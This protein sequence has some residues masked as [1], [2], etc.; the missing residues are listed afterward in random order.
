MRQLEQPTCQFWLT[1]LSPEIAASSQVAISLPLANCTI[2]RLAPC[3]SHEAQYPHCFPAPTA[4]K[5]I[6]LTQPRLN[7][8][9][10]GKV[11]KFSL[12]ALVNMLAGAK[13]KIAVQ[14]NAA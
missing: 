6:R 10:K 1:H 3:K 14:V 8:L 7:D 12:D 4:S 13:L 9:L 5:R 11:D 2:A